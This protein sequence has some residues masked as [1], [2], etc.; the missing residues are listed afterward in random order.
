[1]TDLFTTTTENS[2]SVNVP[3]ALEKIESSDSYEEFRKH[4][5]TLI[6]SDPTLQ[7]ALQQN[8]QN[9][10]ELQKQAA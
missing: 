8:A 5:Q 9:T 6:Q 4:F 3:A 7:Q 2:N 1:M 10:V